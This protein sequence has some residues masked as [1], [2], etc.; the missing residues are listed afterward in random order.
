MEMFN[1]EG[2]LSFSYTVP[3]TFMLYVVHLQKVKLVVL[4]VELITCQI[5]HLSN[6]P[7]QTN[8]EI[9]VSS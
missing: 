3:A 8:M 9:L 7:K 2:F 1:C 4:I 5:Y 6:K